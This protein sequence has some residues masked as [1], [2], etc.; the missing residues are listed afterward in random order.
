MTTPIRFMNGLYTTKESV[1]TID[2]VEY[3]TKLESCKGS[4]YEVIPQENPVKVYLDVDIKC[5][6]EDGEFY[7]GE[8]P[9]LLHGLLD[10]LK[11]YWGDKYDRDQI[12]VITSHSPLFI[13]HKQKTPTCKVSFGFIINNFTMLQRHQRI[14]VENLNEFANQTMDRE[15]LNIYYPK[16]VFDTNP[17][18]GTEGSIQKIRS[19]N[20]SKPGEKRPKLLFSG[21]LE[22][23]II[24]AFIP[25]DALLLEMPEPIRTE[26][27]ISTFTPV[28]GGLEFQ[29]IKAYLDAGFFKKLSTDYKD[30]TNMG[31]AIFGA[32]GKDGLPLFDQFSRLCSSKYDSSAVEEFYDLLTPKTNG[33][34]MGSIK[35]L[36]KMENPEEYE[37]ISKIYA[38]KQI[39][40][41]M[42][43]LTRIVDNDT[44]A[45]E[46]IIEDLKDCMRFYKGRIFLKRD[47][48]WLSDENEVQNYILAYI[49][50]SNIKKAGKKED[51]A[52]A[53][54]TR[55]AESIRKAVLVILK[56]KCNESDNDFYDKLHTTTK[57]RLAFKDGVLDFKEKRFYLWSEINFEYYST[58]MIP[59]NYAEHFKKENEPSYR[60]VYDTIISD[61]FNPLFSDARTNE[62]L[63]FLARAIT[64][65]SE[66]KN[67]ASYLGNRDCG[68]GVIYELLKNTFGDY[69]KTFEIGNVMYERNR[70]DITEVS[71][72]QYWMIDYEFV[73]LAIS[74][75]TP[76]KN[77]K[78]LVNSK[79]WKKMCGGGDTL[80]ARRNYDRVDTHFNIDTTFMSMG[81]DPLNFDTQDVYEHGIQFASTVK[82]RTAEEI[83]YVKK[84]AICPLEYSNLRIADPTIKT[85]CTSIAWRI[86]MIQIL[87]NHYSTSA[88]AIK[89]EVEDE[90]EVPLRRRILELYEITNNP[91]D[92]LCV[93]YVVTD[94]ENT[95]KKIIEEMKDL[96]VEK[97][98]CNIKK[99][100]HI[101]KI[102]F[103]GIKE[104]LPPPVET[105]I[106]K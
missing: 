76:D 52:F 86:A 46:L 98:K 73:R 84:N 71:R 53:Q 6:V 58:Q 28:T 8:G 75:E 21:T 16:G 85:K 61:V 93:E 89:H 47:N 60:K 43:E 37:R 72:K 38:K 106:T 7:V 99:S 34:G 26:K 14:M 42:N 40:K 105:M 9:R 87:Y 29:E 103:F 91:L 56:V 100:E 82:F 24:T 35:H 39:E 27:K 64:G 45:A 23:S 59:M 32:C 68:K 51:V 36:A 92:H 90:E 2:A 20:T 48:I 94:L 3:I 19:V 88:V 102:C 70:Q 50:Q 15:D 30:W 66:D 78:M 74:Q 10:C 22:Q 33:R 63:K 96:G 25:D 11:A 18:K 80:I 62:A 57:G 13:D 95:K 4:Y 54:N 79:M 77:S 101:N 17:Y 41:S 1:E 67:W 49:L 104:R 83:E 44:E 97:K 5:P 81:N 12:A 55:S 31:F 69:V 65:Y